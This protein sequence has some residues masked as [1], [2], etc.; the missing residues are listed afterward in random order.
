MNPPKKAVLFYDEIF[1]ILYYEFAIY[2]MAPLQFLHSIDVK[3]LF[4]I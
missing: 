4:S 1:C 2:I 3:L